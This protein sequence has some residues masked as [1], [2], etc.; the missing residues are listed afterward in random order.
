M[1]KFGFI[2]LISFIIISIIYALLAAISTIFYK[3]KSSVELS[4][5]ELKILNKN[6]SCKDRLK[7]FF[8]NLF[9]SVFA[10]PIYILAGITSIVA[11]FIF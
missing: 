1:E 6:A 5:L 4:I 11:Y 7:I 8:I 10:P 3:D 2:F 9:T